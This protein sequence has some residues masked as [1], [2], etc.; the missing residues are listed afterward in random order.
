MISKDRELWNGGMDEEINSLE[1][2]ET[3]KL[4]KRPKERKVI[5]CK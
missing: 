3:W 1:A 5:G 4:V 2:N